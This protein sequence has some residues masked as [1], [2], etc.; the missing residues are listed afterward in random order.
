MVVRNVAPDDTAMAS[1]GFI[2]GG[3]TCN[4]ILR[5]VTTGLS[6]CAAWPKVRALMEVR[7]HEIVSPT[8]QTHSAQAQIG[9]YQLTPP[10]VSAEAK[11]QLA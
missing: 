1:I 4:M 11:T 7:T 3:T 2:C 8:A 10:M 5:P 6:V 9:C